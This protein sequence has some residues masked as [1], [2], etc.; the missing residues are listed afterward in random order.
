M[1]HITVERYGE[2]IINLIISTLFLGDCIG[3]FAITVDGFVGD[4]TVENY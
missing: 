4:T 3:L 2:L 1:R